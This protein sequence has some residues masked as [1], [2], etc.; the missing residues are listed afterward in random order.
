MVCQKENIYVTPISAPKHI[1]VFGMMNFKN[2]LSA[3]FHTMPLE[4]TGLMPNGYIKTIY[5][6]MKTKRMRRLLMLGYKM[7]KQNHN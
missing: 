3:Q 6:M 5:I 1:A 7:M 4:K 2:T